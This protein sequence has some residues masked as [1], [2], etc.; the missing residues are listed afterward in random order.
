MTSP[1]ARAYDYLAFVRVLNLLG[2][3][4]GHVLSIRLIRHAAIDVW[5]TLEPEGRAIIDP[6]FRP[7]AEEGP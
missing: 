4:P 1:S 3:G 2:A 5:E 7:G 6:R